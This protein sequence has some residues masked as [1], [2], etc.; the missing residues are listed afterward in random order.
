MH[1]LEQDVEGIERPLGPERETVSVSL[2]DTKAC[3]GLEVNIES[4][5]PSGVY[6]RDQVLRIVDR[7]RH[8]TEQGLCCGNVGRHG[9]KKCLIG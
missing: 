3:H 7:S 6:N 9:L 1:H 8:L 5:F 4:K 2:R